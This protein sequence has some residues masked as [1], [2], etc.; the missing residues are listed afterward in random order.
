MG[1]LHVKNGTPVGNE[2]LCKGCKN[3]QFMTGYRE[4][5][6]LVICGNLHPAFKLPFVVHQCSDFEDRGRPDWEQM[7][8]LAIEIQPV[9]VSK[10][11]KGFSFS[12]NAR[13]EY[14]PAAL[15]E[16]QN[17]DEFEDVDAVAE[18]L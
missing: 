7:E 13:P 10:K 14:E 15:H 1:N 12:E 2:H 8:K 4:S 11:T 17:D 16:G 3:G 9:R 18:C 5:D 6:V